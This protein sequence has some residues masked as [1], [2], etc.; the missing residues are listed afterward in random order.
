[1]IH[2]ILLSNN[3]K[4]GNS[5]EI[6]V[7]LKWYVEH[8]TNYFTGYYVNEVFQL[9]YTLSLTCKI[10][11]STSTIYKLIEE[12]NAISYTL[13]HI[14]QLVNNCTLYPIW[15]QSKVSRRL[16]LTNTESVEPDLIVM[17]VCN[18]FRRLIFAKLFS[19]RIKVG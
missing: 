14:L 10:P 2:R 4:I 13:I 18:N 12:F 7:I 1:M 15:G 6:T 8:Q 17:H 16:Q 9:I 19:L 3:V 11:L 5:H